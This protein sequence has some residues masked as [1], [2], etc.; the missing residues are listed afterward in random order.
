MD[1]EPGAIWALTPGTLA[2]AVMSGIERP[3]AAARRMNSRRSSRPLR[4]WL[5]NVLSS[6]WT[7]VC[8]LPHVWQSTLPRCSVT[9]APRPS[10][11]Y[12]ASRYTIMV[13]SVC[14]PTPPPL[15]GASRSRPRERYGE[16][17]A[18]PPL[19]T[20]PPRLHDDSPG[21]ARRVP[22]CASRAACRGYVAGDATGDASGVPKMLLGWTTDQTPPMPCPL[23]SPGVLSPE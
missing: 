10:D 17:E 22:L 23:V 13:K 11:A 14:P 12:C 5:S 2:R 20:R 7:T 9:G 15:P 3:S 18:L 16:G 21:L 1:L 19:R 6:A 8:L 4:S